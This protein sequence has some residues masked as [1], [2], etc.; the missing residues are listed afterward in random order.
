MLIFFWYVVYLVGE[1]K[2]GL[3]DYQG[4]VFYQMNAML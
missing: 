2:K 1:K 3:R 4:I